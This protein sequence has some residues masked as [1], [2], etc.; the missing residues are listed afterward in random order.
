MD[1]I[2]SLVEKIGISG[3]FPCSILVQVKKLIKI[4]MEPNNLKEKEK[5]LYEMNKRNILSLLKKLL[6]ESSNKEYNNGELL[7]VVSEAIFLY[8]NNVTIFSGDD[9]F[10]F[11]GIWDMES[12][13]ITLEGLMESMIIENDKV[14]WTFTNLLNSYC[15]IMRKF[16]A[17]KE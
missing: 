9:N 2:S 17:R 6:N 3:G 13:S 7:K 16:I 1:T 14:L 4:M 11:F 12:K 15:H 8:I 5:I 10:L